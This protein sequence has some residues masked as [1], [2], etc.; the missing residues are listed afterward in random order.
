MHSLE[1]K[2]YLYVVFPVKIQEVEDLF[3]YEHLRYLQ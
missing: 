1:N 2:Q 3:E